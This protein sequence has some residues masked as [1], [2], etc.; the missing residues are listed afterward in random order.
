MVVER[1]VEAEGLT[2]QGMGRE[3]FEE[4]LW[5]WKEEYGGNITQQLRRLGASCDWRRESFTLD[6]M[7]SRALRQL[8]RPRLYSRAEL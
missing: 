6:D 4:R 1:A 7:L 2:R 3:A 8:W 5:Q